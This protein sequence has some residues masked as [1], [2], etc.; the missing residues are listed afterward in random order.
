MRCTIVLDSS[1]VGHFEGVCLS[2][3]RSIVI[4]VEDKDAL[5]KYLFYQLTDRQTH[6]YENCVIYCRRTSD[7]VTISFEIEE[8]DIDE[9]DQ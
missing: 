4:P 8:L 2:A 7:R 3:T 1:Q 9:L 6:N 5:L